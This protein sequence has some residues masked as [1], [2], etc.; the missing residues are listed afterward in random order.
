MSCGKRSV[1]I[2]LAALATAARARAGLTLDLRFSDGRKVASPGSP[3]ALEVWAQVSGSDGGVA[4]S[5]TQDGSSISAT[6]TSP[7]IWG[8][9][10]T[11]VSAS[12]NVTWDGGPGGAGNQWLTAANWANDVAPGAASVAAFGALG[13]ATSIG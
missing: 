10:V 13:T 9:Y 8:S 1:C 7:G 4:A 12:T 11:L 6:A 5:D 2:A 3:L